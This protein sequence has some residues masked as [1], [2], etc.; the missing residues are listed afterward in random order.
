MKK[1]VLILLLI[2]I[3]GC[4]KTENILQGVEDGKIYVSDPVI[5][6]DDD[7][8]GD[9]ELVLND[10]KIN[11]GYTVE[12]NGD[13]TLFLKTKNLFGV[14]RTYTYQFTHDDIQPSEPKL[15]TTPKS[16]YFKKARFDFKHE[17]HVDYQTLLNGKTVDLNKPI[18]EEGTHFLKIIATK[19]NGLKSELRHPFII[20]NQTYS[21]EQLETFLD[22]FFHPNTIET[23]PILY[24]WTDTVTIV[25][26]GRS[27]EKDLVMLEQ[28]VGTLNKLLPFKFIITHEEKGRTYSRQLDLHFIPTWAFTRFVSEE[29][30]PGVTQAIGLA[31]PNEVSSESG[32]LGSTVL[33]G[34]D[35]SQ[36]ERN[37]AILHELIH[38][39]GL[40]NHFEEDR[41][42]ILYP[43]IDSIV[44]E[45]NETDLKMIEMLYRKDL[46]TGMTEE[47][48][49]HV[50]KPRIIN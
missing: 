12:D 17:E 42:S 34:S 24:K 23:E 38:A 19:N 43:F 11:S 37:H 26:H 7:F 50:L 35:I 30:Y 28:H 47:D 40:Y 18:T 2:F 31:F 14:K 9:Y 39:I 29:S 49:V 20:D 45:L 41:S 8:H 16:V 25:V 10:K 36:I 46:H 15:T 44:S 3:T 6:I 33:V 5:S 27:T 1:Y 21:I 32:I 4:T 13:Y 48:V 22:F